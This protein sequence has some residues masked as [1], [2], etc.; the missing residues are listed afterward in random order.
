MTD[1][2]EVLRYPK[3]ENYARISAPVVSEL[4]LL[5]ARSEA[6]ILNL[7]LDDLD[8]PESKGDCNSEEKANVMAAFG[9]EALNRIFLDLKGRNKDARLRASHEL[10]NQVHLAQ[11]G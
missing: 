1:I 7:H 11:R 6:P 10:L 8:V 3:M 4:S 5:I 9:V 2:S